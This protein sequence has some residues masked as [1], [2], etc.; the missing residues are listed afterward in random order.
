MTQSVTLL[1][2][3]NRRAVSRKLALVGLVLLT[4]GG[5]SAG[6]AAPSE[7]PLRIRPGV[8][9]LFFTLIRSKDKLRWY[10]AGELY[11]TLTPTEISPYPFNNP[12]YLLLNVAVGGD[13]D[14]N[15][16]ANTVFP[17]SMPVEWVKFYNYK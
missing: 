8:N 11:Y 15:P 3:R 4:L 17:Q 6:F 16:A 1:Q 5:V 12:F 13:F 2:L 9:E 7:S 14:G 10:L